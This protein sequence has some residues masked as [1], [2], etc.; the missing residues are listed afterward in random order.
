MIQHFRKC[1]IFSMV[2]YIYYNKSRIKIDT[3][4]R[5][6]Y[7]ARSKRN[8]GL[9]LVCLFL[10]LCSF[11]SLFPGKMFPVHVVK[12]RENIVCSVLLGCMLYGDVVCN[13]FKQAS[14]WPTKYQV[15]QI[16]ELDLPIGLF[17]IVPSCRYSSAVTQK[18]CIPRNNCHFQ[19]PGNARLPW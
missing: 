16:I 12:V 1:F 10:V 13:Y 2:V 7:Y 8:D 3:C 19:F 4:S 9:N 15:W 17:D 5:M 6:R 11:N 14:N 18:S